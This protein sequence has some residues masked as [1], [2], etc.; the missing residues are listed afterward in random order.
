MSSASLAG[1]SPALTVSDEFYLQDCD[2]SLDVHMIALD[3]GVAHPMVWSRSEG[4]GRVAY[5]AMGH[6]ESVW[7][8]SL[9]QRL[10]I[11]ALDW[12]TA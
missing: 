2:P 11:Q 8:H 7:K 5:V 12:L 9:Y 4:E 6:G 3:R 1:A 10:V